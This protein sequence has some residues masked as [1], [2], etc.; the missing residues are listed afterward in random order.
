MDVLHQALK[1]A[2][3]TPIPYVK[4]IA[5]LGLAIWAACDQRRA[6]NTA[7][8]ALRD[9]VA[10]VVVTLERKCQ[11]EG[12]TVTASEHLPQLRYW[13]EEV[14]EWIAKQ[15]A[16]GSLVQ[17]ARANVVRDKAGLYADKLAFYIQVFQLA[18]VPWTGQGGDRDL[19]PVLDKVLRVATADIVASI[20]MDLDGMRA[21]LAAL[22]EQN[23]KETVDAVLSRLDIVNSNMVD[24]IGLLDCLLGDAVARMGNMDQNIKSIIQ[25]LERRSGFTVSAG[26]AQRLWSVIHEDEL[27]HWSAQPI[28]S[29][30]FG[31]VHRAQWGTAKVAVKRVVDVLHNQTVRADV[32]SEVATWSRLNHPNVVR[33]FGAC[34]DT[35]RP[36]I[37]MKYFHLGNLAKRLD[38][39]RSIPRSQRVKWMLEVC[40]GLSHIHKERIIH[41]DLKSDNVLLDEVNG[42]VVAQ[43]TDFGLSA[44]KSFGA[45]SKEKTMADSKTLSAAF[46]WRAPE[47]YNRA[48]RR[49]FPLDVFAFGMTTYEIFS[50]QL[51]F[52]GEYNGEMIRDWIR[53]GETPWEP[54]EKEQA[55]DD[56]LWDIIAKC[57]K[58]DV[59]QRASLAEVQSQLEIEHARVG[60]PSA[61]APSWTL[62][63]NRPSDL[64]TDRTKELLRNGQSSLSASSGVAVTLLG[65]QFLMTELGESSPQALKFWQTWCPDDSKMT[66]DSLFQGL[67]FELGRKK[68]DTELLREHLEGPARGSQ[69]PSLAAFKTF[70]QANSVKGFPGMF[71]FAVVEDAHEVAR[72]SGHDAYSQAQH[73]EYGSGGFTQNAV[74]AVKFYQAAADEKLPVAQAK[75]AGIYFHGR[76]GSSKQPGLAV[77]YINLALGATDV[78]TYHFTNAVDKW[79]I[80]NNKLV[81]YTGPS[82]FFSGKGDL[83]DIAIAKSNIAVKLVLISMIQTLVYMY[84]L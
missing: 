15:A 74:T 44:F 5:S 73:Y 14:S 57:I 18:A 72:K 84:V 69:G 40:L 80:E 75:M 68:I 63:N 70:V 42:E 12:T 49:D 64:S 55:A 38:T 51:P 8:N 77:K 46:R 39:D 24:S 21:E 58:T 45:K 31:V 4:E 11:T 16:R 1:L 3:S 52:H 35:D 26:S 83:L 71:Q 47:S 60:A 56:C 82:L 6:N 43:I 62:E 27:S 37:V 20:E 22:M 19:Q 61:K 78:K 54:S 32:A 81:K 41:G 59:K 67:F 7:L 13:L 65:S 10:L 66:W 50:G 2:A 34:I 25:T 48:Y 33:L 29:G 79:R 53:A 30:S 17:V 28:G 9:K 76:L 36:F 23:A